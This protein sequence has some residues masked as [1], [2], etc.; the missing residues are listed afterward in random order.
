MCSKIGFPF[1]ASR[2]HFAKG[3]QSML[4]SKLSQLYEAASLAVNL[5]SA[6]VARLS[7]LLI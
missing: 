1:S 6:A 4:T 7:R 2:K 3:W 5:D